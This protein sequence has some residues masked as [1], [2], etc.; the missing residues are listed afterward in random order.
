MPF[1][2]KDTGNS[3]PLYGRS[4]AVYLPNLAGGGAERLHLNLAPYFLAAGMQVTFVLDQKK[5]SLVEAVPA[6]IGVHVLGASRQIAA[7]P[8]LRRYLAQHRPDILLSNIE[9]ANIVALWARRLA[10]VKTR[11]IVTQHNAFSRQ[12]R[13]RGLQWRALPVLYRIFLNWTDAIVTVSQGVGDEL[14]RLAGA[15]PA[16]V[17]TIHNGVVAD[18]FAARA[19]GRKERHNTATIVAVG[20]LVEQKDYPTLLRAF[21]RVRRRA[22]LLI[23]GEGPED[24]A[25][26][27]AAVRL[28]IAERLEMPGFVADPMPAMAAAD[29]CVLSSKFE[30]FGNVLAEALAC[31][32]S[33]VSTDCPYG[34]SEIL[35]KGEFGHLVPVG[36][37][38]ALA[39]AIEAA[40]DTPFDPES[41]KQWAMQFSVSRCAAKYLDL[42]TRTLGIERLAKPSLE[43]L[44]SIS[45]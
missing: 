10:N 15:N 9:Q 31:G 5:G 39:A 45:Q 13:R 20:R 35:G 2:S 3:L 30:G 22:K 37:V 8:L 36:D 33:C 43:P 34:P 4:I 41:L 21:A 32:T 17:T 28:G 44:G 16:K 6:G 29:V 14:I 7:L 18:D 27:A 23:L 1:Y 40:I 42:F 26:R 24:E 38:T 19:S 12:V 25:L 11:V